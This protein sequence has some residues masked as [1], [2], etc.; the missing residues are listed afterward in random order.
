MLKRLSRKNIF[1]KQLPVDYA[2]HSPQTEALKQEMIDSVA[3]IKTLSASIDVL[4]TVTG[5]PAGG[6]DYGAAYWAENIRQPVQFARAVDGLITDGHSKFL[7]IGPHPVLALSI[8]QCLASRNAEGNVLP[9]LRRG[10]ND[11]MTLYETLADLYMSGWDLKWNK[12][13]PR[14]KPLRPTARLSM[15]K[16]I[17][18]D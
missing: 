11:R 7:E 9:S 2:F 3:G 1:C 14:Q 4:S 16:E 10:Q 13:L 15:A 5:K 8:S 17:L 18:L 6:T 12:H